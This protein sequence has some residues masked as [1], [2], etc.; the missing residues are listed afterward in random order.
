MN[1]RLLSTVGAVLLLVGCGGGGNSGLGIESNPYPA[2]LIS[3]TLK[4]EYLTA[5]NNARASQ[6]D[7]HTEGIKSAVPALSWNQALYKAAY[8]HSNDLVES[9]TVSH[10]GSGTAS[11]W[12]GMDLGGKKS[13]Y[14][15]RIVNNGYA[16]SSIGENITVGTYRDT[17]QK[18][19][20]S[21]LASD[22]H[23]AN[24]MSPNYTE[25][26]MAHI[27]EAGTTYIH[28]W[29]QDFGKPQ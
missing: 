27:E 26:G 1:I 3:D 25:V 11:D 29:T 21:W 16:W 17:A 15:E 14:I 28:Y 12:T 23:C 5:I 13:T 18:A 8:E 20:D 4:Q 24:L 6:Q 10:D 2:P 19:V 9:D 7:C 22:R